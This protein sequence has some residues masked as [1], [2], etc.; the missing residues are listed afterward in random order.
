MVNLEWNHFGPIPPIEVD[1]IIEAENF[2]REL[3]EAFPAFVA[4]FNHK[5][6]EWQKKW[7][8]PGRPASSR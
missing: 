5:F 2:R 1:A 7:F 6:A 3:S 4:D 8:D